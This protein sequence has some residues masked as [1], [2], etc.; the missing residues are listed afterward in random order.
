MQFLQ[1]I[2]LTVEVVPGAAGFIEHVE[3]FEGGLRV[4]PRAPASGLL[5][6][7]G[8]LA[9]VPTQFRHYLSGNLSKGMHR[10]CEE[11]DRMVLDPDDP[12]QRAVLQTG[13]P[14]AT[15]WAWA[16]GKELGIPHELIIQS[17]EYSGDGPFIRSALAANSYLGINGMTHA[18]FCVRK[19]NPYRPLPVYPKLAFWLQP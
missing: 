7:A 4:D 3:V 16:A 5:H 2:G 15:A 1:R 6:E 9:I 12:L 19:A 10:I 17:H 11:L 13:D 18:G 8:H 14:E